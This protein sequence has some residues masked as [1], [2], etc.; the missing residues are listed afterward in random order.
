MT[1]GFLHLW[2]MA[3]MELLVSS[4][5]DTPPVPA[6]HYVD[7]T[8]RADETLYIYRHLRCSAER[9]SSENPLPLGG[10]SGAQHL[11]Q[12]KARTIRRWRGT[13]IH[14]AAMVAVRGDRQRRR[15]RAEE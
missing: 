7:D 12:D 6:G 3:D 4:E 11:L 2:Q 14:E 10:N 1:M 8:A 9:T 15:T 13:K 5:S